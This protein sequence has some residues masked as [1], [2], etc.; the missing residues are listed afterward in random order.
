MVSRERPSWFYGEDLW[1]HKD[2]MERNLLYRYYHLQLLF[3]SISIFC[4]MLRIWTL[5]LTFRQGNSQWNSIMWDLCRKT[6]SLSPDL[7]PA[8]LSLKYP[9]KQEQGEKL[10]RHRK[11]EVCVDNI[12]CKEQMGPMGRRSGM[13]QK[14]NTFHGSHWVPTSA[15]GLSRVRGGLSVSLICLFGGK[16]IHFPRTAN[17]SPLGTLSGFF[18]PFRTI[19]SSHAIELEVEIAGIVQLM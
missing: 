1:V 18:S 3:A 5:G 9:W 7:L 15:M 17:P 13:E 10:W 11:L 12:L 2:S 4:S 16:Q 19:I 14:D 6:Q 8:V